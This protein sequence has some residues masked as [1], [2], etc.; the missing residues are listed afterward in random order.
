MPQTDLKSLSYQ[1]LQSFERRAL[2]DKERILSLKLELKNDLSLFTEKEAFDAET[3]KQRGAFHSEQKQ[4]QREINLIPRNR[5]ISLIIVGVSTAAFVGIPAL[6]YL[7]FP[8]D[9]HWWL[10]FVLVIIIIG[11]VIQ[12]FEFI[13]SGVG[14]DKHLKQHIPDQYASKISEINDRLNKWEVQRERLENAIT[15]NIQARASQLEAYENN[16]KEIE[17]NLAKLPDLKKR[18]RERERTATVAAYHG[19]ART[20]T[21]TIRRDFMRAAPDDWTCPYCNS[22]ND[23]SSCH[24]DHIWPISRGGMTVPQ[25][26][27]L[28]CQNCNLTKAD[29]TLRVFARNNDLDYDQ[30]CS[31]LEAM[32]K[33][34]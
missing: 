15:S 5:I 27:V 20:G 9:L 19:E 25:N 11:F 33:D 28:I 32:G 10:D 18:A 3:D 1:S 31:R 6:Y 8:Y 24:A 21:A 22:E 17:H 14:F 34:V 12:A 29:N 23:I 13:S 2:R 4:V 26:M 16:L 30:I 7:F